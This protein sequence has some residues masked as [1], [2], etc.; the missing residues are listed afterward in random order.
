MKKSNGTVNSDVKVVDD[1]KE[2]T[3]KNK[4]KFGNSNA[5]IAAKDKKLSQ[6]NYSAAMK[7]LSQYRQSSSEQSRNIED[8][9]VSFT[10]MSMEQRGIPVMD[11]SNS[12]MKAENNNVTVT[13]EGTKVP[14]FNGLNILATPLSMQTGTSEDSD[15]QLQG[16]FG[17]VS[18]STNENTSTDKVIGTI[19]LSSEKDYSKLKHA[20]LTSN[21]EQSKN[22]KSSVDYISANNDD[23]ETKENDNINS[24]VNSNRIQSEKKED[25]ED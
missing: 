12:K 1:K 17:S 7:M 21:D 24:E 10:D 23:K 11:K 20:H 2:R 14:L 15:W 4:S 3:N 9:S 22:T 13:K 25:E 18:F 16:S 8:F 19:Q 5:T 6:D